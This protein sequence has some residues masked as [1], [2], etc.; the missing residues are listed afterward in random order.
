MSARHTRHVQRSSLSKSQ[1]SRTCRLH[2]R[3]QK[4]GLHEFDKMM[5]SP[6]SPMSPMQGNLSLSNTGGF[7]R[8]NTGGLSPSTTGEMRAS[9]SDIQNTVQDIEGGQGPVY[10]DGQ[11]YPVLSFGFCSTRGRRPYN[12]DRLMMA[13]RLGGSLPLPF[14]L[15]AISTST[16]TRC[17]DMLKPSAAADV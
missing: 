7:L 9:Q 17:R 2:P 12:E 3:T 6:M 5:G 11:P 10:S 15:L 13:P 8:S 1:L 4:P 16:R 14:D